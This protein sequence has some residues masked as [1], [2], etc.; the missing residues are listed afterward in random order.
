MKNGEVR[1]KKTIILGI[2]G[3][4]AAYKSAQLASNLVKKGHDVHVIMTKNATEFIAPL[5]LEVLTNN[6]VVTG[7]FD[8]N[9]NYNVNHVSLSK[10]ADVF[11]VAPATAN[12][13]AK[14]AAGIA[15]DMLTT[16]YL[17]LRCPILVAPAM[18]TA[19]LEHPT[20]QRNLAT[21]EKDGARVIQ[22]GS[23]Y[24]ACG[25]VGAGRLAAIDDIEEAID[26]LLHK[27]KLLLGKKVVITAGP[28][29]EA[30]DPVRFITNHSS[31][32]MGYALARAAYHLGATVHLITGPTQLK[33]PIG[34]GVSHVTSADEMQVAAMNQLDY[35]FFIASAAVS[36]FKTQNVSSQKIK[37]QDTGHDLS[38]ALVP[39]K[40]IVAAVA[41]QKKAHQVVCG[42]AMETDNLVEN[43]QTKREKK[44]LDVIVAN[45]LFDE[46]AGFKGDTNKVTIISKDKV[47]PLDVMS[48]DDLAYKILERLVKS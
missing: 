48:K 20:T 19:M 35:D 47:E 5:T 37:K 24:L 30:I 18:N 31:G 12:V 40:D 25:D 11:V 22:S 23:G 10:K 16:T 7:T 2:S 6:K 43:A 15:D 28:T 27:E 1:M 13:L 17:A 44:N 33:V 38:L 32:K 36:D 46:G 26:V 8:R 3:G 34:I 9:F 42:F 41:K 39:N 4:I 45:H 14:M 21:L 29:E